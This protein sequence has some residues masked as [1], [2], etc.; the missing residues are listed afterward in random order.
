MNADRCLKKI[1]KDA[2][3]WHQVGA[4]VKINPNDPQILVEYHHVSYLITYV[5]KVAKVEHF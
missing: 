1:K 4:N 2:E 3:F 5:G